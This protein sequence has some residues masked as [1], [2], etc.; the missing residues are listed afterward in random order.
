MG[1]TGT[2]VVDG[3]MFVENES[4]ADRV[5][6]EFDVYPRCPLGGLQPFKASVTLSYRPTSKLI[7]LMHFGSVCR[8]DLSGEV[9]TAE[10]VPDRV[11]GLLTG[12]RLEGV[13]I[14]ARAESPNHS[15][16]TVSK[17]VGRIE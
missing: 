13:R 1:E 5:S 4:G 12:G 8:S 10:Q 11:I 15:P 17:T 14:V 7:E 3:D 16:V 9:M 2:R 6:I